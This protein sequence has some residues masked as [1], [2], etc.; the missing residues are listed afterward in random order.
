MTNILELPAFDLAG[1]HGQAGMLA[2]QGL[3]AVSSSVL[4]TRSP[5]R[6]SAGP[7]VDGTDLGH[8]RVEVLLVLRGQ[9]VA[10]PMRLQLPLFSSRAAWRGSKSGHN[11]PLDDL[12]RDLPCGPLAR[13]VVPL[14]PE[15][16]ASA[17]IWQTCS[18][19][20]RPG[21]PGRG[22]SVR[23]SATLRSVEQD[24]RQPQPP[25]TP[26]AHRIGSHAFLAGNLAIVSAIRS[27]ED[28]ARPQGQLLGVRGPRTRCSRAWRSASEREMG[29]GWGPRMALSCAR[30]VYESGY[31]RISILGIYVSQK[32]G[33]MQPVWIKQRSVMR[34]GRSRNNQFNGCE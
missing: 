26:Q 21:L 24:R 29:G 14:G 33:A 8:F 1:R 4:T 12:V 22:A 15:P 10:P 32:L 18:S 23:R 20:I 34:G 11:P 30:T 7:P 13:W 17:T 19:V 16:H 3:H 25:G 2:L 31:E 9:P 27:R 5:R 6:A 28:H